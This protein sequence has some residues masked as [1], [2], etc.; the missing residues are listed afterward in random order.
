MK[1]SFTAVDLFAGIGG[2]RIAIERCGGRCTAFSEINNDATDAYASNYSDSAGTN[3]GDIT[4]LKQLPPHDLLT[5]GVPCQSW[6][7]AGR[8]LGFD[9]DRGQLWNDA[10]FLLNCSRPRAFIFENVKGLAD[11]RNKEALDHILKRIK[12]AGYFATHH[13]LN[14]FDYGVPQSRTRI[15]IIGFCEEKFLKAFCLPEKTD[16]RVRLRDIMD[17]EIIETPMPSGGNGKNSPGLFGDVYLPSTGSTSL[18]SN[19]NG[20]NDYFLF[21]DIRNGATTIHSWD[22]LNTDQ[23]QKHICL[24]LLRN[25]RKKGFGP[26]DGNPLSLAH[27]Q[28]LD[29]TIAESELDELVSLGILK[30][31][32]YAFSVVQEAAEADG[33]DECERLVLAKQENNLI[34]PDKL[35]CDR[36][37]K[38]GRVNIAQTLDALESKGLVRCCETRFEFRHTKIST[39]LFGICRIFLPSSD[40]FPTLVA[41]DS[42]DYL[43]PVSIAARN[44]KDYKTDFMEHVFAKKLYRKISKAEACR[45]QGFPE[46]FQLPDSRS[47]WMKLLGNSV[48][49]PVIEKLVRAVAETGVFDKRTEMGSFTADQITQPFEMAPTN[50]LPVDK[51][52]TA[53]SKTMC[54][55]PG[56][57]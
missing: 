39:G 7:I 21:N 48:S 30:T 2:F 33:L 16:C 1:T 40:I 14:S 50:K 9:D 29:N 15:Y 45:I 31:E 46:N 25:R 42:N 54:G 37:L 49:V 27:F 51:D 28:S 4:A 13:V 11:P 23:R 20:F 22:M 57:F 43:T 53:A 5:G 34:I 17:D 38:I 44:D 47:R 56:L 10:L 55:Q 36:K 24:L 41:S 6:S 3:L 26:L 19:N 8:N 12:E 18:S 35:V 52:Y 32:K